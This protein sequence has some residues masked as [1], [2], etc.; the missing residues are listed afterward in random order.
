MLS[1]V[2]PKSMR[3]DAKKPYNFDRNPKRSALSKKEQKKTAKIQPSSFS[4]ERDFKILNIMLRTTVTEIQYYTSIAKKIFQQRDL[5]F[6]LTL[7]QHI[8]YSTQRPL[9]SL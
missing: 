6:L 3:L 5:Q 4:I 2:Q 8:I 9:I 1:P 7:L